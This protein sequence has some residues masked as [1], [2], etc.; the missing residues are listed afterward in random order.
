MQV[1]HAAG[2][3]DLQRLVQTRLDQGVPDHAQG[4]GQKSDGEC[5]RWAHHVAGGA[6]CHPAGQGGVGHI[7]ERRLALADKRAHQEG[8]QGGPA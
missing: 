3:D 6:H 1:V 4:A 8:R 5:S 2:V 7:G